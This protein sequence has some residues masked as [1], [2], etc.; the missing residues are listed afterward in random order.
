MVCK[1][2]APLVTE[3]LKQA[4]DVAFKNATTEIHKVT[5]EAPA[6]GGAH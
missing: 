6:E 4:Y 3:A 5:E 1:K 2:L